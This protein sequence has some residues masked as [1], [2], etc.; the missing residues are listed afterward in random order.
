[1][2]LGLNHNHIKIKVL[3][4]FQKFEMEKKKKTLKKFTWSSEDLKS[5]PP[6]YKTRNL[7]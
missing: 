4:Y 1:M 6:E 5:R 3:K 7:K 2:Y